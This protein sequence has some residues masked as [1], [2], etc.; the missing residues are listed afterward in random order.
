MECVPACEAGPTGLLL[1]PEAEGAYCTIRPR[2]WRGRRNA[3]GSDPGSRLVRRA[4]AGGRK[5]DA[6]VS[7]QRVVTLTNRNRGPHRVRKTDPQV[8]TQLASKD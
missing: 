3:R 8:I 6:A 1:F 2:V 5:M 7:D 4:E